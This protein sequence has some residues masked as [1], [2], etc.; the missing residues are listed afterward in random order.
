MQAG[1]ELDALIA[2]KVM[3]YVPP[4]P[5]TVGYDMKDL[6]RNRVPHYSTDIA[7]AWQVVEKLN[8][9]SKMKD[10]CLYFDPSLNKWV[11]SEWSGGREFAEGSVEADTAPHAICLAALKAIGVEE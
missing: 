2:E 1:R 5:G 6:P 4:R 8:L 10:G 3:G 11:I 9:L 7:A